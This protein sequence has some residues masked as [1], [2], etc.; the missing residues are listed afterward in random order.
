MK[1]ERY[2]AQSTVSELEAGKQALYSPK[3]AASYA[4]LGWKATSDIADTTVKTIQIEQQAQTEMEIANDKVQSAIDDGYYESA[5]KQ[6]KEEHAKRAAEGDPTWSPKLY[7]ENIKAINSARIDAANNLQNPMMR[8]QTSKIAKGLANV[9]VQEAML[10]AV[11]MNATRATNSWSL[12]YQQAIEDKEYEFA[13][14]LLQTGT[15]T[16]N[17]T[18]IV[19]P[20][21]GKEMEIKLNGLIKNDA[22]QERATD[23]GQIYLKDQDKGME[24][25]ANIQSDTTMDEDDRTTL[26]GMISAEFAK[27]NTVIKFKEAK[28]KDGYEATFTQDLIDIATSKNPDLKNA[29]QAAAKQDA[30]EWGEPGSPEALKKELQVVKALATRASRDATDSDFVAK[31]NSD[32]IFEGTKEER[33][34]LERYIQGQITDDM[35][36]QEVADMTMRTVHRAGFI[37]QGMMNALNA[38]LRSDTDMDKQINLFMALDNAEKAFDLGLNEEEYSQYRYVAERMEYNPNNKKGA[39]EDWW[40]AKKNMKS[41]KVHPWKE[42]IYDGDTG[43]EVMDEK[44]DEV[45]KDTYLVD[46]W[47]KR[48]AENNWQNAMTEVELKRRFMLVAKNQLELGNDPTTAAYNAKKYIQDMGGDTNINGKFERQLNLPQNVKD[49]DMRHMREEVIGVKG[50]FTGLFSGVTK[51]GNESANI[52]SYTTAKN[53]PFAPEDL[54][55]DKVRLYVPTNRK[56]S[57]D[58]EG[59]VIFNIYYDGS[60][61]IA[62]TEKGA[63]PLTVAFSPEEFEDKK[64]KEEQKIDYGK[65]IDK[66]QAK[67]DKLIS[68]QK[69]IE[70]GIQ[71]NWTPNLSTA[72]ENQRDLLYQTKINAA[73]ARKK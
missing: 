72:I 29:E 73:K 64:A 22:F 24:L 8:K 43:E 60:P 31:L 56:E 19:D 36:Q 38:G 65:Q 47:N 62:Q 2:T 30:G 58:N 25:Y 12:T 1:I 69:M 68:E 4:G 23:I 67:L 50:G 59:N 44:W 63:K 32:Y 33:E 14:H 40:D 15:D 48:E 5:L 7:A 17:G 39:I 28:E 11:E 16:T 9:V 41:T 53:E 49:I 46:T 37:T 20:V 18:P 21:K 34:S 57:R 66:E 13:K 70:G 45:M 27:A 71:I 26:L 55:P 52:D 42:E 3:E 6:A 61:L 54:D 35:T 51:I 10:D